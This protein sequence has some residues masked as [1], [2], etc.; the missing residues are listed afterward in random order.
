VNCENFALDVEWIG[1]CV[2][3]A[4]VCV[5]FGAEEREDLAHV[6]DRII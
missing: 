2:V 5:A 4:D 1:A 3:G 6:L